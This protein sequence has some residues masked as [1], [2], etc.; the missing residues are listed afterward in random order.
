MQ[1]L[2]PYTLFDSEKDILMHIASL[3]RLSFADGKKMECEQSF[4]NQIASSYARLFGQK[5]FDLIVEESESAFVEDVLQWQE[6]LKKY[7][8]R[9]RNLVKDMIA[10]ACADGDYCDKERK[11]IEEDAERL[12]VDIEVVRAI[13]KALVDYSV[14]KQGLNSV[15]TNGVPNEP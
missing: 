1:D 13:E 11:M 4:I 8:L 6:R 15:I 5:P 9:A 10:L 3:I 7:P 12:S 2:T 14:A